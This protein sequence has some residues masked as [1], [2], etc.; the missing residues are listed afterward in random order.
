MPAY[1][2][3][4]LGIRE[5][6]P[7]AETCALASAGAREHTC[8]GVVLPVELL[9]QLTVERVV[10]FDVQLILRLEPPAHPEP[11]RTRFL[12]LVNTLQEGWG[13]GGR[14]AAVLRFGIAHEELA[15]ETVDFC[16]IS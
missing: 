2:R 13:V 10:R 16:P 8:E 7:R 3:G 6:T 5:G 4:E 15:S 9:E 11:L 12:K 14:D 1:P